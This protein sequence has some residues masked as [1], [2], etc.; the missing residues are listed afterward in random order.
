[1]LIK[2][3]RLS[4]KW[5]LIGLNPHA[6]GLILYASSGYQNGAFV[7]S[8]TRNAPNVHPRVDSILKLCRTFPIDSYTRGQSN[9]E[10][11][12]PMFHFI[13]YSSR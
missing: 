11:G 13:S 1:M 5:I 3:F 6:T 10:L 9:F 12:S 2:L 4:E 8:Y 7:H